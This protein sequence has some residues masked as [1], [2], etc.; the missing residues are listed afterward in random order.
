MTTSGHHIDDRARKVSRPAPVT[1]IL[2]LVITCLFCAAYIR[3]VLQHWLLG[4]V[5]VEPA[6]HPHFVYFWQFLTYA[7]IH[8][9]PDHFLLNIVLFMFFGVQLERQ[10]GTVRFALFLAAAAVFPALGHAA[11]F[12]Q[13]PT[14]LMGASGVVSAMI[15]L[16]VLL[17]APEGVLRYI[18]RLFA[19]LALVALITAVITGNQPLP[20]P[21][22]VSQVAH[23]TGLIFGIVWG[24]LGRL[25]KA[26]NCT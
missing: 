4:N 18:L 5:A 6:L 8:F 12:P 1:G 17:W 14:G 15:G 16:Q 11:V 23:L 7:L 20:K 10:Y 22:D 2:A 21:G 9:R 26:I 3:P 24:S 13:S 19:I 25:D